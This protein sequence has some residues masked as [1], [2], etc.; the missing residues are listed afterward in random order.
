MDIVNK[1]FIGA[2]LGKCKN[3]GFQV[4]IRQPWLSLVPIVNDGWYLIHCTNE[5][6]HNYFGME[7]KKDEL[8]YVDFIE[9]EAEEIMVNSHKKRRIINM[10]EYVKEVRNGRD[11]NI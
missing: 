11:K 6:C 1:F 8:A 2:E 4:Q 10:Q 9:E 3:C 7:I 5:A